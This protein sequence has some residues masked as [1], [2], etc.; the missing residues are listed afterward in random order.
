M[1]GHCAPRGAL[2]RQPARQRRAPWRCLHALPADAASSRGLGE[3][4]GLDE[5]FSEDEYAAEE[6]PVGS[7]PPL[8]SSLKE[9]RRRGEGNFSEDE[10]QEDEKV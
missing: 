7:C 10:Y 4:P 5:R 2:A 9:P 3:K 1:L 8:P 6:I